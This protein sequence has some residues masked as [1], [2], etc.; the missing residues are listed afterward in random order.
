[1][2]KWK[3]SALLTEDYFTPKPIF[4]ETEEEAKAMALKMLYSDS[5]GYNGFETSDQFNW[6]DESLAV[7]EEN[8]G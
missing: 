3:A 1:M 4:A 8:Y 2:K 7:W 6:D 5:A